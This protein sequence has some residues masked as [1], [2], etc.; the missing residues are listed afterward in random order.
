[1]Q[2]LAQTRR[3]AFLNRTN[4]FRAREVASIRIDRGPARDGMPEVS[5]A[6]LRGEASSRTPAVVRL[7]KHKFS[8]VVVGPVKSTGVRRK[9]SFEQRQPYGCG[10]PGAIRGAIARGC[11]GRPDLPS[12]AS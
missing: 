9:V 5:L 2:G 4:I 7:G 12:A 1:M 6:R 10:S 8:V 3:A 11:E